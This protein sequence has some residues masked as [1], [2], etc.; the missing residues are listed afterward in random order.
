MTGQ[1]SGPANAIMRKL[2]TINDSR[3]AANSENLSVSNNYGAMEISDLNP[4]VRKTYS[5]LRSKRMSKQKS[6]FTGMTCL[7]NLSQPPPD[8]RRGT[9]DHRE[10]AF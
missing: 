1:F 5:G 8:R 6:R 2:T 4:A 7:G 10:N 3:S 9:S